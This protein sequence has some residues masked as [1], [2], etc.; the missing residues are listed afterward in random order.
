VQIEKVYFFPL[1]CAMS[2]LTHWPAF[3]DPVNPL[4][5][6]LTLWVRVPVASDPVHPLGSSGHC[7]PAGFT[8]PLGSRTHGLRPWDPRPAALDQGGQVAR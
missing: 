5:Y 4:G 2:Q 6:S 8:D 7:S 1:A 3:R